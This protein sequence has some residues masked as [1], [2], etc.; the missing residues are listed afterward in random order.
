MIMKT[1][2]TS[3]GRTEQAYQALLNGIWDGSLEPG[4]KLIQEELASQLGVS[5]HPIQQALARLK[6]EGVLKDAP[7]R[8]LCIPE[9]DLSL[10]HH[11][12]AIRGALD[13]LAARLAA[14]QIKQGVID[15]NSLQQEG[16]TIIASGKKAIHE[17]NIKQM[18]QHDVEFHQ[19]IYK[20]SGNPLLTATTGQH[21]HYL[22][23][24][25]GLV[26]SYA[27]H[28]RTV[29]SQHSDILNAITAGDSKLAE[30]NAGQHVTV[31]SDFLSTVFEEKK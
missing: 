20:A 13:C 29:A 4:S 10:M 21:W 19:L 17:G 30:K 16:N 31:A 9:L 25:M 18:I 6:S 28:S 15:A 8:G 7:G 23:R 27:E 1:I 3:P 11:H 2:E 12:Y 22:R 14:K 5:R 26:L 24:V